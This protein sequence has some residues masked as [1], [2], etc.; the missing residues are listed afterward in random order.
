MSGASARLVAVELYFEDFAA[1]R[2][3]YLDILG[4]HISDEQ[5]GNPV[6]FGAYGSVHLTGNKSFGV[7][8]LPR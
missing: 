8:S 2:K 4:L 5:P 3:F 7:L 1:A 6:K